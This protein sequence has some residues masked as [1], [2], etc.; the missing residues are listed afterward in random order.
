VRTFN[1]TDDIP[2]TGGRCLPLSAYFVEEKP[3]S[4][5]HDKNRATLSPLKFPQ[6]KL[7]TYEDYARLTPHDSGNYEL[8]NG[9][10][11]FI[12]SPIPTHQEISICL[13]AFLGMHVITLR[14]GKLYAAPMDTRFSE[15]DTFQPDLLFISKDRLSIIGEQKIEGAPDLVVEILSP[16]NDSKEMSYKRHVYETAG[17]REYWFIEP[18]KGTLS[19]YELVGEE[20]RWQRTLSATDTL[21]AIVVEGFSLELKEIF[22]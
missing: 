8:H 2:T 1:K 17:V 19:Q 11:V 20:L 10:I 14:L 16:G 12:A 6:P 18:Q 13:S 21:H 22:G 5:A 15:H 4:H 7:L 3:V 9:K